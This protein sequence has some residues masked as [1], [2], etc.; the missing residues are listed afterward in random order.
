MVAAENGFQGKRAGQ[1]EYIRCIAGQEI[2]SFQKGASG[3]RAVIQVLTQGCVACACMMFSH[4]CA[5]RQSVTM[6]RNQGCT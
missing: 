6:H 4:L 1:K 3:M 5:Y 2:F